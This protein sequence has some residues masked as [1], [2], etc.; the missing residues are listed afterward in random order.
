MTSMMTNISAMS[1]L[2]TLRNINSSLMNAQD[3]VGSGYRIQI[4]KDNAAYWSISTTMRSDNKAISAAD[5]AMGVGAAK[6]DVAYAGIEAVADVLAEFKAKLVTAKESSVDLEKVQAELEQLKNQVVSIAASASF[7]GVNWLNTSISDINDSNLNRASIVSSF[8][9]TDDGVSIGT[10]VLHLSEI[11]LFNENGGGILQADTRKLKTLGGIRDYDTYMDTQG[12]IHMDTIN[13]RSGNRAVYDFNFTGPLTF[14]PG[15]TISFDIT[16]DADNPADLDPPY[17]PGKTTSITIDRAMVDAVFPSANGVISNYTEYAT[18]LNYALSQANTG[19]LATTYIDYSGNPIIDR[20]GIQTRENSG[21]DGSYVEI[22]N[23]D[24]SSVGSAA[25]L[26]EAFE[27]GVRGSEMTLSFTP[28]EVYND[29]DNADG[30]EVSFQFGVNGSPA[31]SYAFDRTYVNDVLGKDTGK[32]ETTEEMVTLLQSLFSTDWPDVIIEDTSSTTISIR[33]DKDVDRLSGG[34]TFIGFSGISVSIEPLAEQNFLDIHIVDNPDMLSVYLSYIDV[35][36]AD[37]INAGSTLGSIQA[38]IEMQQNF[39]QTLMDSIDSGVSRLVD[40]DME[41]AS[42]RLS[43]LQ[44]QQQLA[45]QSLQIANNSPQAIMQ[46]F[47]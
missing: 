9:R 6:V 40:A 17:H 4:A 21:L 45:L 38:R 31:K 33:S 42:A 15:D 37:V 39:A 3:E 16:V 34:R 30:V 26:A 13:T 1:A 27:F 14:D 11:S 10:A 23:L 43:A 2:Q 28:F 20:I 32:I 18:L 41:E 5:D 46:L 35:V 19:A 25:G 12:I 22:S 8:T 36:M 29:G 44:T 24:Y 7:N 47:Q